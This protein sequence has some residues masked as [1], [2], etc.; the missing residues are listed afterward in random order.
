MAA[1]ITFMEEDRESPDQYGHLSLPPSL[2]LVWSST[3]NVS[4]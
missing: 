1:V 3:H 4:I 2:P